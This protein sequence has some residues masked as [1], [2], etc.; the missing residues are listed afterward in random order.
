MSPAQALP[1]PWGSSGLIGAGQSLELTSGGWRTAGAGPCAPRW[2]G[3]KEVAARSVS[4]AAGPEPAFRC[5]NAHT[6]ES[7]EVTS[8]HQKRAGRFRSPPPPAP[9]FPRSSGNSKDSVSVHTSHPFKVHGHTRCG[10]MCFVN[11]G[12]FRFIPDAGKRGLLIILSSLVHKSLSLLTK[13]V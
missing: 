1:P 11:T 12:L 13:V 10:S 7:L 9:S 8:G 4:I 5:R 2:R 6:G 3:H